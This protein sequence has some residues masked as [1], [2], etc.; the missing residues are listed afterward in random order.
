MRKA[1]LNTNFLSVRSR[2]KADCCTK[3]LYNRVLSSNL[4]ETDDFWMSITTAWKYSTKNVLGRETF[5]NLKLVQN[6]WPKY[7]K[8]KMRKVY[9]NTNFLSVRFRAKA[10]C[11]TKI[12]YNRE[13]RDSLKKVLGLKINSIKILNECR[14]FDRDTKNNGFEKNIL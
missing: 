11:C 2:T 9:L 13:H 8:K 12:L 10:D 1:Y 3:L 6:L 4:S 5:L 14:I 7:I